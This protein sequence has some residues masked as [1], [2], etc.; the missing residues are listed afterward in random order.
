MGDKGRISYEDAKRMAVDEDPQVR[1]ALAARSDVMPEILFYLANDPAP[2]VREAIAANAAT[3]H[4][5]DLHL[6]QDAVDSVRS[7]LATKIGRV[8]PNVSA[9]EADKLGM[10]TYE[11]L[12]VLARD[13]ITRVRQIV[14]EALKDVAHAPAEVINR[15]ARDAELAVAGPILENSPVLTDDDLVAIVSDGPVKGALAS[16]ANRDRVA[17]AVADAVARTGD[18]EAVGVL[19]ANPSAQIREDTLDWIVERA[20]GVEAWHA[21]LVRRPRLPGDAAQRIAQFVADRL[22]KVL[23]DRGD[24]DAGTVQAL[25]SEVRRR[26]ESQRPAPD[27]RPIP[28][29]GHDDRDGEGMP[30][31]KKV[32]AQG[33]SAMDAAMSLKSSSGLGALTVLD[34]LIDGDNDFVIA[35]LAVM[36]DV[37]YAVAE[38]IVAMQSAKG[39]VALAWR[40]NIPERLLAQLQNKLCRIPPDEMLKPRRPGEF[41][42]SEDEMAW[43]LEFFYQLVAKGG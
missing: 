19:L 2:E 1:R 26:I 3:P 21:P 25:K 7:R 37:P 31:W 39:I 27:K 35:S 8:L 5:A 41:P 20:P 9:E 15:L 43:Q 10:L 23:M 34:A 22:L 16:I 17:G 42:L 40:G 13:Q 38:K 14:A 18:V 24:F 32:R 29:P 4:R 12:D 30:A 28:P 33:G 11:A 6:A 36:A